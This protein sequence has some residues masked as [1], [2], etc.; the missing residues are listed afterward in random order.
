MLTKI[1]PLPYQAAAL[2]QSKGLTVFGF[3][4]PTGAGK[5]KGA[6]DAMHHP[7][8]DIDSVLVITTPGA[9]YQWEQEI[10]D[11][12]PWPGPITIAD[13]DAASRLEH[14]QNF[15]NQNASARRVHINEKSPV[16]WFIITHQ[17]FRASW[18]E[19]KSRLKAQM[20]CAAIILDESHKIKDPKAI[21]SAAILDARKYF[22]TRCALS[23]TPATEREQEI[24]TQTLFLDDGERFGKGYWG[25]MRRFFN[26]DERGWKW[27]LKHRAAQA[28][29]SRLN[30]LWFPVSEKEVFKDM[31]AAT[32]TII[33][34][35]MNLHQGAAYRA[36]VTDWQNEA[37][38]LK[39]V[40]ARVVAQQVVAN[41]FTVFRGDDGK[42]YRKDY[43]THKPATLFHWLEENREND[44][45]CVVFCR[46][47]YDIERLR[48]I[49]KDK[50]MPF[51]AI[52]GDTTPKER[53]AL[54][55]SMN[56][57][58]LKMLAIQTHC[59]ESLDGL[60]K[61]CR[62]FL[63]YSNSHSLAKRIQG[64]GRGIRIGQRSTVRFVDFVTKGTIEEDILKCFRTKTDVIRTL[65]PKLLGR[66][67][68]G[69][70]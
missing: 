21:Q 8:R 70:A 55:Q 32:Y 6:I 49:A 26:P 40:L 60:H 54:V 46:F 13:G 27:T 33:R 66:R 36:L 48:K 7:S 5:T 31:P 68:Y 47:L 12:A 42:R 37:E 19:F 35:P 45:P 59:T 53:F 25:F 56:A 15:L 52:T 17:S 4:W 22:R 63:F 61:C 16:S 9:L 39:W 58:K 69:K 1:K 50:R 44:E 34:V 65:T 62:L 29:R 10:K 14:F 11:N 18:P 24:F 3:P 30:S 51:A 20:A 2:E 28:I 67:R 43:G 57:G 38:S 41:G 64:E 23:A